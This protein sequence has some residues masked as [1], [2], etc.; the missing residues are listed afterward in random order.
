MNSKVMKV[1][2]FLA[3]VILLAAIAGFTSC[4]KVRTPPAPFDKTKTWSFSAD[5]QPIFNAN[6]CTNCHPSKNSPD[7]RT[8][9]S[10]AAL[11]KYI[12]VSA[13]ESSRLYVKMT[14]SSGSV[15]H[16]IKSTENQKLTVL[17][18]IKQGASNN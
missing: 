15:D 16:S 5:I 1:R 4:E 6:G 13:P 8:G 10:F 9:K 3:A 11:S 12:N 2:Q 17:Y 18:W 14:S 7:L